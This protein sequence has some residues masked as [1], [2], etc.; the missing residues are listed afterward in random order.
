MV[1]TLEYGRYS[2]HLPR[3]DE[4]FLG[5]QGEGGE[6]DL[7]LLVPRE[8]GWNHLPVVS[9]HW[10]GSER[11]GVLQGISSITGGRS[12]RGM[13][14]VEVASGGSRPTSMATSGN[15]A[16]GGVFTWSVSLRLSLCESDIAS[17]GGS[18]IYRFLFIAR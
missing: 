1:Y 14:E 16:H 7:G 3:E 9:R 8:G 17:R 18:V 4:C 11:P 13:R 6:V 2:H 5:W 10:R 12:S 15:A